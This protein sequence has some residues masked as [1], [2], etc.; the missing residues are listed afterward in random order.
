VSYAGWVCCWFS[1]L[2]REVF[3]R[4]LRFSLFLKNQHCSVLKFQFDPDTEG[5]RVVGESC[6]VQPS[7]N[8]SPYFILLYFTPLH[9]TSLHFT[10]LYFTLLYLTLFFSQCAGGRY[11]PNP[12]LWLVPGVGRI[13]LSLPTVMVTARKPLNENWKTPYLGSTWEFYFTYGSRCKV[14]VNL[15]F[16]RVL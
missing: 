13:F 3:L 5:H 8:T 14:L 1:S 16:L 11:P 10:S 6:R 7:L 12:A 4:V 15:Q 2:L 9:F